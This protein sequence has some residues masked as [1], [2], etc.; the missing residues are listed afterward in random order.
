LLPIDVGL[1]PFYRRA[2]AH[3]NALY[4]ALSAYRAAASVV[5]K[6]QTIGPQ[7]R[8][9]KESERIILDPAYVERFFDTPKPETC[10]PQSGT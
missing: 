4:V 5:L 9:G 8:R 2:V 1:I 6:K 10:D 7:G 3:H